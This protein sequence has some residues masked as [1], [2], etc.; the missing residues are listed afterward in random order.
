MTDHSNAA[1]TLRPPH[2]QPR[3]ASLPQY[4]LPKDLTASLRDYQR[5]GVDWLAHLNHHRL[6]ALLADD[7]GLG[8][9][10]QT[11]AILAKRSLVIAPTSVI[12]NWLQEIKKFRLV[13]AKGKEI[14]S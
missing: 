4:S 11:I 13:V 9:T 5:R 10:L 2:H 6:G 7:M 14:F 3:L 12:P 1:P 8:K